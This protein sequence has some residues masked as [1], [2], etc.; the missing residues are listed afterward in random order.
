MVFT[1]ILRTSASKRIPLIRFRK[2]GNGYETV[3]SIDSAS[4][5]GGSSAR[6]QSVN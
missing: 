2:G 4:V 3:T 6:T 1:T 5:A